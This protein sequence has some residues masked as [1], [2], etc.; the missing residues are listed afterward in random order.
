MREKYGNE[1]DSV[2]LNC[3][4]HHIVK[5]RYIENLRVHRVLKFLEIIIGAQRMQFLNC[6]CCSSTRNWEPT[7]VGEFQFWKKPDIHRGQRR[8]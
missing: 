4:H 6:G 8:F 2:Q 1:F 3:F 5:V 7:M